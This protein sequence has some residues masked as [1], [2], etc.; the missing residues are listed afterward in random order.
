MGAQETALVTGAGGF[1]GSNLVDD[2]LARGRRVIAIDVHLDRLD[3]LRSNPA[4]QLQVGDVRDAAFLSRVIAGSDIPK[5]DIPKVDIIFHL[6][7]AHLEVAKS[8]AYFWETNVE[9]VQS[10][11]E[12]ARNNGVRRFVHTSSVG[13]YGPLTTLPADEASAC[14]PDILYE[15]TK[16]E[17][18]ETVTRF[19]KDTG[20]PA[21][22]LRPAW[23]YG[24]RCPRTLKLFRTIKKRRFVMVGEG[25]NM[26]HPI[27]IR[28]MLTAFELA[29]T[30]P[31][32]E[33]E[34]FVVASDHAVRLKDL[35]TEIIA[36]QGLRFS[37][38]RVPMGAMTALC[39]GM[40]GVFKVLGKEPPFSTRSL[41]FFTE[42]SAFDIAKARRLLGFA[43]AVALHEGLA[44]TYRHYLA[45]GLL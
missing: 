6:A 16:L 4:C 33:G 10:L 35:I 37:P 23:V 32:I 7:S 29:A 21:V 22:I 26:R 19:V 5:V 2:Q 11:L 39:L 3:H 1:I 20:F 18:E 43:P 31:G 12:I 28:D 36:V 41:K 14:Y 34:A 9:A 15:R 30:R 8:E 42:S 13:V 44:H 45:E 38:I 17:G 27:H 25:E 24:P 40:E